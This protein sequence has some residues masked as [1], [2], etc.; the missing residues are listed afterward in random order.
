MTEGEFKKRLRPL[1]SYA[2]RYSL[3]EEEHIK[4][5]EILAQIRRINEKNIQN[6]LDEARKEFH[7]K[8]EIVKGK[9]AKIGKWQIKTDAKHPSYVLGEFIVKWFGAEK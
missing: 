7:E 8:F 3:T 4:V 1:T 6:V 5:N 9:N 2:I